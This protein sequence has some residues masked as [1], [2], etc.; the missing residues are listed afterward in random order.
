MSFISD[1]PINLVCPKCGRETQTTFAWLEANKVSNCTCGATMV[2][3]TD[4]NSD[5]GVS[6]NPFDRH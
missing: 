5:T 6:G 2:V 1:L 4:E 3:K